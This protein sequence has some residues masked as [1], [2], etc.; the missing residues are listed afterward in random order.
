MAARSAT[1]IS[2]MSATLTSMTSLLNQ[3]GIEDL[4][5]TEAFYSLL[6]KVVS[7]YENLRKYLPDSITEKL[8]GIFNQDT[9]D[10]FYYFIGVCKYLSK[11]ERGFDLL[12][13]GCLLYTSRR[14]PARLS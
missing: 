14:R 7:L 11:G 6:K 9:V 10:N 1:G 3:G 8:D 12:V 13:S 4:A 5:S 2:S